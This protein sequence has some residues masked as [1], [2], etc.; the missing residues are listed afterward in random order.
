[1]LPAI[2]RAVMDTAG[3]YGCAVNPIVSAMLTAYADTAL[4]PLVWTQNWM[5]R[6]NA[7]SF[8]MGQFTLGILVDGE[9]E[10]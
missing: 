9:T 5:T 8:M 4:A 6:A 7:V 3:R 2:R 1:M 10:N